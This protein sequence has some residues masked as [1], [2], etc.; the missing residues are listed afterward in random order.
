[1]QPTSMT[2]RK[3][4]A[5]NDPVILDES[6]AYIAQVRENR[7]VSGDGPFTRAC[8]KW[9]E[10]ELGSKVLLTTSC[11]HALEMMAILA[12]IGPGDEVIMPSYTFVSSANAFALRGAKIVFVDVRADTMNIDEKEVEQ[13]ITAKTK[14]VL[15]VHYAGT[16]CDMDYLQKI[17]KERNIYLFEDAAQAMMSR[18]KGRPLGTIGDMGA[19]SFH[20]TK[21]YNCGEGGLLIINNPAFQKEAEIIRE[22]GTDRSSFLRGE[23][24]KYTWQSCGSSYLP[25][26][27][28]AA[29]LYAQLERAE[30]INQKRLA[31]W[32]AYHLGL[33]SLKRKGLIDLPT[34]P[35]YC[36]QNAH[37]FYI[38]VKNLEERTNLIGYLKKLQIQAVSHY[39]PLH[40]SPFGLKETSFHGEDIATSKESDR[41]LRLPLSFS[42]SLQDVSH[43]VE[44]IEAFFS[45]DKKSF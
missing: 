9:F 25:S 43:I 15:V 36:T 30:E 38:K 17:T 42:L 21:N 6:F 11:T 31:I 26:E 24:D 44:A 14:A 19:F 28:N 4:I 23:V 12:G 39:V 29:F 8:H 35:E 10:K 20:E 2:E 13:A 16:S 3:S 33:S 37:M 45:G 18:Y 41:L 22:K 7:K 32:D 34:V 1:M 27:L 5:F 40:S